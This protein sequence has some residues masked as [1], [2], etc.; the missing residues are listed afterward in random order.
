MIDYSSNR[1]YN[2]PMAA[3]RKKMGWGGARPGAGRKRLV[4][5]PARIAIDFEQAQMDQLQELAE[6]RDTSIASLI[7]A[8]VAQY[9][10]TFGEE[11][12]WQRK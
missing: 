11:M 10:A 12:T 4:Q 3:R 5:E 6:R 1:N 7:R 9:L 8:A 2:V